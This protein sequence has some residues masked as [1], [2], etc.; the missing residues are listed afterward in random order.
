MSKNLDFGG[1][2]IFPSVSLRKFSIGW[3]G[4]VDIETTDG[5]PCNGN[6]GLII[7]LVTEY[8]LKSMIQKL[9]N[10]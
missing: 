7:N 5:Y 8:K 3:R 10:K 6:M 2:R 4:G 9:T 1:T